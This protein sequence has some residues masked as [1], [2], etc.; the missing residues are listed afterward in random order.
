[1]EGFILFDIKDEIEKIS[2][3]LKKG[4]LRKEY[5]EMGKNQI[6]RSLESKVGK[7]DWKWLMSRL[8]YYSVCARIKGN[9]MK[10]KILKE[11]K[12]FL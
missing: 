8:N 11:V 6:S 5:E 12:N 10:K 2:E 7:R 9:F 1:M 3:P 4:L